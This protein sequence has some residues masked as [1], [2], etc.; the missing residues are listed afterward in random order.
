MG[1]VEEVLGD[2]KHPYTINLKESIPE[3]DPDKVWDKKANL[4]EMESAEY[5]RIGCKF[6][7]RC[8]QAQ[9]ICT[10]VVPEDIT[11]EGRMVKCHMFDEKSA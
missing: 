9:E 2:P 7:G 3:A 8:P 6:A 5:T 4:A 11:V 1:P 10:Q